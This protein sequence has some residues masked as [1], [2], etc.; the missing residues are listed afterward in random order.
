MYFRIAS[1]KH[2]VPFDHAYF[3]INGSDEDDK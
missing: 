2:S 1:P 3:G